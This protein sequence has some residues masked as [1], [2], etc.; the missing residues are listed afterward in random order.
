MLRRF[1]DDPSDPEPDTSARVESEPAAERSR[2]SL[3]PKMHLSSGPPSMRRSS[4][5]PPKSPGRD[6]AAWL[7]QIF[8]NIQVQGDQA[9]ARFGEYTLRTALQPV[10]SL[11]LIHIS[12]PTRPY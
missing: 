8:A 3:P 4:R 7:Q 1:L 6:D 9:H 12:E 11:S 5:P 10:L 2:S